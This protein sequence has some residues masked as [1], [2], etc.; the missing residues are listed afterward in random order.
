[1]LTTE[2]AVDPAAPPH[3]SSEFRHSGFVLTHVQ[4]PDYGKGSIVVHWGKDDHFHK[5]SWAV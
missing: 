1:M 3:V 2:F 5:E 4:L